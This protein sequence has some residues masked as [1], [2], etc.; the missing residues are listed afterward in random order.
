MFVKHWNCFILNTQY[1]L[2][3]VKM[4]FLLWFAYFQ[5]LSFILPISIFLY[6]LFRRIFPFYILDISFVSP[7][8]WRVNQV[9]YIYIYISIRRQLQTTCRPAK[10][11]IRIE[12]AESNILLK[13]NVCVRLRLYSQTIAR[14]NAVN[15]TIVSFGHI[16]KLL[17][18][19]LLTNLE[20][21]N[22]R[23]SS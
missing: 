21:H 10:L 22:C 13:Q 12:N 16:L 19:L 20:S 5:R 15:I 6:I 2:F 17:E 9:S 4:V 3:E 8:C 14:E 1:F 18:L 7:L 23:F 11:Y